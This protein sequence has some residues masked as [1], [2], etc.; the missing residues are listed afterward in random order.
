MNCGKIRVRL[1]HDSSMHIRDY[2]RDLRWR[3]CTRLRRM[4][5]S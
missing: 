2:V 3:L 5:F 1:G 4:R